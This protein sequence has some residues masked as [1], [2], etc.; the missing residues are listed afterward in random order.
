TFG[1]AANVYLVAVCKDVSFDQIAY[2]ECSAIIESELSEHFLHSNV[3]LSEVALKWFVYVFAC[4]LAK[5][6]LHGFVTVVFDCL[7][8]NDDTRTSFNY[9]YGNEFSILVKKLCHTQLSAYD[10]FLHC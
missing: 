2:I 3:A 1:S 5:T 8:L 10:A 9:C 6:D 7:F 4:D